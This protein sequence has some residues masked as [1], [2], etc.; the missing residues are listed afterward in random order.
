VATLVLIPVKSFARAKARLSPALDGPARADL[1]ERLATGVVAAVA[2]ATDP[3][4]VVV[5]GDDPSVARWAEAA[6]VRGVTIDGDLNVAATAGLELARLEGFDRALI[7][8]ADLSHP[9]SLARLVTADDPLI[10]PD[11]HRQGTNV[12]AVPTAI[13]FPFAYGEGSFGR[14]VAAAEVLGLDL[15][16][17]DDAALGID[18]DTPDDLAL[19]PEVLGHA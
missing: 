4:R 15:R 19:D 16:V 5:M 8:H 18:V 7:A 14:H 9:E 3:A 6:G 1:A 13:D 2:A 17:V 12:L 10:V 11:R